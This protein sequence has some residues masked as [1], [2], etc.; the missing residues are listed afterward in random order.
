MS[1]KKTDVEKLREKAKQ[2]RYKNPILNRLN[3]EFIRCDLMEM[4]EVASDVAYF[5]DT[6]DESLLE[7]LIGDEDDAFELKT[8]VAQLSSDVDR[9]LY[10]DIEDGWVPE[11]FDLF[12]ARVAGAIR[13]FGGLSGYDS[14]EGDYFGL[15]MYYEAKL[16]VK[17][18]EKKLMQMTKKDLI[19][20]ATQC[21]L[22]AS[23]YLALRNRFDDL[24]ESMDII[25]GRNAGYLKAV[26]AIDEAYEAAEKVRFDRYEPETQTFDEIAQML[27]D[28]AWLQ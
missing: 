21:F 12:F 11:C 16:A 15:D 9:M 3:L 22:I 2:R 5:C 25:R 23:S 24:T 17:E 26:K 28:E 14:F 13:S 19:E 8:M 18:A 6:E 1:V 27:P 7:N 4:S 10:T 20:A